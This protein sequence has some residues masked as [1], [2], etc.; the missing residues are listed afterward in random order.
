MAVEQETKEEEFSAELTPREVLIA[1]GDD[2]DSAS[3]DEPNDGPTGEFQDSPAD[4]SSDAHEETAHEEPAQTWL[5][6]EYFAMAD[7]YGLTLEDVQEMSGPEELMRMGKVLRQIPVAQQQDALAAGADTAEEEEEK[8]EGH[9]GFADG[10]INPKWFEDEGYDEVTVMIAKQLL[11]TQEG[12]SDFRSTSAPVMEGYAMEQQAKEINAFHDSLDKL[13]GE[14]FGKSIDEDGSPITQLEPVSSG[15]RQKMLEAVSYV[16]SDLAD[17]QRSQGR[18]P[19][20]PGYD[21]L[22]EMAYPLAFPEESEKGHRAG[23]EE[24]LVKQSSKRRRAGGTNGATSSNRVARSDGPWDASY[25]IN[26]PDLTK[27]WNSYGE[28]NGV[29]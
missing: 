17:R 12:L 24:K 27:K 25:L 22:A 5:N 3:A 13:D 15:R 7:S 23:R 18:T 20:L 2:P 29:R 11:Q 1:Q 9:P 26:D 21:K 10:K 8:E 4:D 6:D 16:A 28:T 14:F 19:Q